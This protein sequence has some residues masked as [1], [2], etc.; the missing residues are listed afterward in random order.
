MQKKVYVLF[1]ILLCLALVLPD[2][3]LA[4]DQSEGKPISTNKDKV[5]TIAIQ[6]QI[7]P[8]S[9]RFQYTTTWDGKPKRAIGVGGIN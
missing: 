7:A 5:L 1:G 3:N 4:T 2:S 9:P 6:G 8:A